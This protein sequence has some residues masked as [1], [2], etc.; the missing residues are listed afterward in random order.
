MKARFI[1]ECPV[2]GCSIAKPAKHNPKTEETCINC[3][4]TWN[5]H[6]D[7]VQPYEKVNDNTDLIPDDWSVISF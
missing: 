3:G 5:V 4:A 6:N 2:C 7:I 1:D